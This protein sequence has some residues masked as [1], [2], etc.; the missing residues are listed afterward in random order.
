MHKKVTQQHAA[1][2]E[3]LKEFMH[4]MDMP[5]SLE[6]LGIPCTDENLKILED[7]LIDS[8]YVDPSPESLALLHEAMKQ[9]Q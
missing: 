2:K 5:L 6:E 3:K 7:Y 4:N 8:P 1:Q 9:M